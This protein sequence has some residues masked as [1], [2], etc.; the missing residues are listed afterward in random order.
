MQL[1]TT[2]GF[3]RPNAE[4]IRQGIMDRKGFPESYDGTGVLRFLSSVKAGQHKVA[5]P[6]YSHITYDIVKDESIIVDRPEFSSSR[7]STSCYRTGCPATAKRF[8]SSPIFSI[9]RSF[10]TRTPSCWSNG[11]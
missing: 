6:V 11:T 1:V 9:F 3:L 7:A 10:W 4:L 2:D 8:R 5:V